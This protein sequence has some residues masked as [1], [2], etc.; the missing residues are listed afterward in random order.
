LHS[1]LLVSL[2][3]ADADSVDGT[4]QKHGALCGYNGNNM[5]NIMATRC[6]RL[7]NSFCRPNRPCEPV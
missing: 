4:R 6:W 1:I 2:Q 5:V 7:E 3:L